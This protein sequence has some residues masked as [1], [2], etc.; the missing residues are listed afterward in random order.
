MLLFLEWSWISLARVGQRRQSTCWD[1]ATLYHPHGSDLLH[2][3]G[4]PTGWFGSEASQT[5]VQW[6]HHHWALAWIKIPIL[7]QNSYC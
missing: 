2:A 7:H 6:A 5:E 4:T 3:E 1:T